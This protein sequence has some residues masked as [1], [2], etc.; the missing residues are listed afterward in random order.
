MLDLADYC[1]DAEYD[2]V[3]AHGVLHLLKPQHCSRLVADIQAATRRGGWNVHVVFTDT[4]TQ[5]PD[6]KPYVHCA[7]REGELR[8]MYAR[9]EIEQFRPYTLDD[10]H[11]GGIHHRHAVNMI[12]ARRLSVGARSIEGYVRLL[13]LMSC[14]LP[15]RP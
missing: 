13:G 12:V 7:F 6:L 9:W 4:L 5:P 2:L 3:I 1:P 8:E 14:I 11:A 15:R 10:D